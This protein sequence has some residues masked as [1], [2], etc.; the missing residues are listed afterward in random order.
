M[1]MGI[2][3]LALM[4]CG[5]DDDAATSGP[6]G[7][8]ASGGGGSAGG[9][10][11]CVGNQPAPGEIPNPLELTA[12]VLN[13]ENDPIADA[14]VRVCTADPCTDPI[15]EGTTDA[16]GEITSTLSS[17]GMP[18]VGHAEVEAT[19]YWPLRVQANVPATGRLQVTLPVFM[20]RDSDVA[21]V[22]AALGEMID[23][24]RGVLLIGLWNCNLEPSAGV[25]VDVPGDGETFGYYLDGGV[26]NPDLTES[27][28]GGHVSANVPVG[29]AMVSSSVEGVGVVATGTI[30]IAA[31]TMSNLI[32][33]PNQ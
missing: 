5:D 31:G 1:I 21:D 11:D 7:T 2:A 14:E 32:L 26:P 23:E 19:G 30:P 3:A 15:F 17:N 20:I 4:A 8:G 29:N 28:N 10:W 9:P 6:S 25:T 27:V 33:V 12:R 22:E 24:T 18:F 13:I 16:S